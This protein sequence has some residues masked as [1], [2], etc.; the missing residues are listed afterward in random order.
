VPSRSISWRRLAPGL[1]TLAVL[2]ATA[3]SIL[4][5]AR[6]GSVH[7]KT[8]HLYAL[9]DEASGVIKGTQVWL[10]GRKVGVVR[11]VTIRPLTNDGFGRVL[12]E[13]EVLQK[14]QSQIRRDSHAEIRSGGRWISNPVVSIDVGS[15]STPE[16]RQGDTIP[17]TIQVDEDAFTADVS[18]AS[19][20]VPEILR[21][22]RAIL[23]GLQ[24]KILRVDPGEID[25]AGQPRLLAA[26]A[27]SLSERIT[28]GSG[29]LAL[30]LRDQ[31][32]MARARR[33][34]ARADSLLLVIAQ[35]T[36]SIGRLRRD[37]LLLRMLGDTRNE[38]SIV[39]A[40]LAEPRGSAGRLSTDSVLLQQL[41]SL[42]RNLGSAI[43][44]LKRDPASYISF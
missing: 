44:Q 25:R 19:R 32:L 43:D 35:G 16:L 20:D 31:S 33:V 37:T 3:A 22:L 42:E 24:Q 8:Y 7:G 40:R 15:A 38:L 17:H 12:L 18:A 23:G 30:A 26:Q 39:R 36:G 9:A 4:L 27:R 14:Y 34:R 28:A 41:R 11:G 6:V 21:N 1:L 10:A 29:T 13:L 5:F 2:A